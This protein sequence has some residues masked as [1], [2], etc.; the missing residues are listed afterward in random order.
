MKALKKY[1]KRRKSALNF[2]LQKKHESFTPDTFHSIRVEIK[3]VNALVNLAKFCSRKFKQKKTFKPFKIIFRQAGKVRELQLE[4]ALLQEH[5]G[6]NFAIEYRNN[7]KQNIT[8][9]TKTFFLIITPYFIKKLQKK[10]KKIKSS[11]YK[12]SKKRINQLSK[13]K[14]NQ[15]KKL[16][17]QNVLKKKQIHTLRKKLQEYQYNIKSLNRTKK[18]KHLAIKRKLPELLGEWHDYSKVVQHLKKAINSQEINQEERKQLQNSMAAF[19]RK[20]RILF[21]KIKAS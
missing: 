11:I 8:E 6:R 20:S 13:K 12:I 15:I 19:S 21:S 7:L 3:K 18:K 5:Y 1:L 16:L 10:F 4:E 9:D 14:R 17:R 2:L